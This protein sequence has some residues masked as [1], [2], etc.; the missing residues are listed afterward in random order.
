V[1]VVEAM[2]EVMGEAVVEVVIVIMTKVA[3]V[4]IP[5]V[6]APTKGLPHAR[7][8]CPLLPQLGAKKRPSESASH[9]DA[10]CESPWPIWMACLYAVCPIRLCN[11]L[12]RSCKF[13]VPFHCSAGNPPKIGNPEADRD[14]DTAAMV[15]PA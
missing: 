4:V 12:S 10:T 15:T 13:D 9:P 6:R 11:P 3:T 14:A 7:T 1:I 8:T 5:G 2:I